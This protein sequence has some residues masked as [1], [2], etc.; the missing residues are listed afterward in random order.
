MRTQIEP[1]VLIQKFVASR[2]A[3]PVLWVGRAAPAMPKHRQAVLTPSRGRDK[4]PTGRRASWSLGRRRAAPV[5]LWVIL[6]HHAT[7]Y[8]SPKNHKARPRYHEHL[9]QDTRSQSG[10]V[11][12]NVFVSIGIDPYNSMVTN[13][14]ALTYSQG[15]LARPSYS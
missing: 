7:P 13:D 15:R 8:S 3:C 12:S 14:F 6:Q 1:S 5:M 2:I 11:Y 10:T 4:R 9:N